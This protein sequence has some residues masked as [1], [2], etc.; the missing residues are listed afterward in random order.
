MML[1]FLKSVTSKRHRAYMEPI[2]RHRSLIPVEADGTEKGR[3]PYAYRVLLVNKG[4]GMCKGQQG[5]LTDLFHLSH[6][7]AHEAMT[8]AHLNGQAPIYRTTREIAETKVFLAN[9]ERRKLVG[10]DPA[11]AGIAFDMQEGPDPFVS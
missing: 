8:R 6:D 3:P 7:D 2:P 5:L 11:L 1:Y 10:T 9:K 4:V